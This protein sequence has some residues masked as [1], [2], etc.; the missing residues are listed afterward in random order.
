MCVRDH[1]GTSIDMGVQAIDPSPRGSADIDVLRVQGRTEVW[2]YECKGREP[3]GVVTLGQVEDWLDR[4]VPRI[5]A[6]FRNQERFSGY[7]LG[8]AFWTSGR[9]A[10]EALVRLEQSSANTKRYTIA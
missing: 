8:V 9:F 2:A 1:E 7:R 4:Q 10:P 3:H 5:D 6:W